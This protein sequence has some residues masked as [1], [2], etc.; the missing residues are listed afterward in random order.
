MAA[1]MMADGLPPLPF[2]PRA[3]LPDASDDFLK[4]FGEPLTAAL[5]LS[6][7]RRSE[8]LGD[9]FG[10]L[11]KE[12]ESSIAQNL[13]GRQA[14]R[15]KAFPRLRDRPKAP[16]GAGAYRVS[17]AQLDEVQRGLLFRGAVEACNGIAVTHEALSLSVTQVG[18]CLVSYHADQGS[19]VHRLYRRDLRATPVNPEDLA[20]QLVVSAQDTAD[21]QPAPAERLSDLARRGLM[22]YAE[23]AALVERST[24][25]W[26]MG[27]GNPVA[28]EL[29]TGSGS[30]KLMLA[31][32]DLLR[33][34]VADHKRFV[35]VP[36]AMFERAF[37]VLG[38]ALAPLEYLIVDNATDYMERV[39]YAS[40]LSPA[41]RKQ[42]RQFGDEIGPQIVIGC[43][44]A[45][46]VGPARIF[47]AHVDHAHEAAL[48]ALADSRLHEHR[49]F[50]ALLDLADTLCRTTFGAGDFTAMLRDAYAVAGQPYAFHEEFGRRG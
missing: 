19:W 9:L 16:P 47:Y 27:H 31:S 38:D 6:S 8:D 2:A 35:F 33:R 45:S 7:W 22:A 50:P 37:L 20:W 36:S 11:Q 4:V 13:P 49:A 44:R 5:D 41:D 10:R 25:P 3:I 48:I 1:A 17:Q 23:R 26:R 30:P 39:Y 28:Y 21:G 32:L 42:L 24:A 34:L 15:D 43:Y 40:Y 14:I 18:V 46:A 12:V 29:L